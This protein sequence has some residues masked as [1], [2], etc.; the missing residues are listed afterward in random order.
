[1]A[2]SS[3]DAGPALWTETPEV[4]E[5]PVARVAMVAAVEGQYSYAIPPELVEKVAVGKR[6]LVPFGRNRR[7]QPAFCLSVAREAWTSTLR[8]L[9]DVI[10]DTPLLSGPLMELGEWIAR[11]YCCPLGRALSA[12]VPEAIRRQSG[13][14]SVRRFTLADAQSGAPESADSIP[15]EAGARSR[16]P[17]ADQTCQSTR[18]NAA[19]LGRASDLDAALS[20][21]SSHSQNRSEQT[22]EKPPA[23]RPKRFSAR[24]KAV[25]D[26]L[27]G[28]PE[29]L[30]LD[31]LLARTGV[32]KAVIVGLLKTG[33]IS[34]QTRRVPAPAPDFGRPGPEPTFELNVDQQAAIS[35]IAALT[36]EGTFRAVLL[37]GVSGSG[38]TEVYI[39]AIRSVVAAGKQAILLV[40][41]IALT[42]QLV[43]RL[44]ARF[45]AVAV[46]HSGLT[47]AKRSLTWAAIAAGEKSV[48]IG[49]RSAVFAPCPN[50]GLIVVDEEQEMSF[51]NQQSPRFNTRDVAIK[52]AQMSSC[53]IIL[54]SATPSL[55]MWH[56]CQRLSHFEKIILPRRVAGL[57]MPK[58]QFVDMQIERQQ[59]KGLHLL[60][61]E[62]ENELAETLKA[63]QQAVLLLNRRGYASYLVCSRCQTTIVCPYCQVNLVFH[64]STG[65]ALCHHCSARMVMPARCSDPSCNGTLVR[66]GMGTQRVEEEVKTKFPRARV[67]RAD[68]DTM[69]KISAYERVLRDFADGRL[70]VLV[71]TQMVAKGLDFPRVRLVGVINAD[72]SLLQPDFRAAERTFQLVTQVAGRA[73]RSESDG[74]VVVQSLVGLS[75]AIQFAANHDYESFARHELAFRKNRGFPPFSRLARVV[76]SYAAQSEASRHADELAERIRESLKR[77]GLPADVLGPQSAPLARLRGQ[78]RFDFLIRTANAARLLQILERLRGEEVLP[79]SDKHVLIDVDPISLL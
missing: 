35:R 69:T 53:P 14:I 31:D 23:V 52:R 8:P 11:Y 18:D 72:T 20:R 70:D 44:A 78:Y 73:G 50:L 27:A 47:G 26:A 74:R 71:G 39:R 17:Q 32:S 43:E 58:V 60:S 6:V 51:K 46:V 30:D 36:A 34:Q 10:D 77:H 42:T 37:F 15:E 5:G 13:F 64:Q 68:S 40:P 4:R 75:P 33:H 79:L 24:Q 19:G 12:M 48:I 21:A 49:T 2:R 45:E 62:M 61:Q 54:G 76:V 65:K 28:E 57:P 16:P 3:K 29:G 1:M 66:F 55:E 63:G 38:K 22:Q 25:L 41:E 9:A 7:P 56:N 59:R 67:A